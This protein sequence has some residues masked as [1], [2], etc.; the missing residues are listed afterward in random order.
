MFFRREKPRAVAFS[1]RL[2]RLRQ[3]GFNVGSANGGQTRIAKRGCA[4]LLV[5][6]GAEEPGV[7]KAGVLIGDEIGY[8]VNGG[9][10]QFFMTQ[11]GKRLPAL[12]EQLKALHD[13]Q[14]DMKEGLGSTSY[15]NTSLGTVSDRHMYDR[16]LG[17]DRGDRRKQ[18]WELPDK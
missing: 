8:L 4:A 14:E 6:R 15:Y 12:A 16:V 1:D 9:F 3:L 18:V 13:F 7:G 17:R 10:Q 2:E 11:S 5:D